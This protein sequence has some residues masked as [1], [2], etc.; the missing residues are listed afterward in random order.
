MLFHAYFRLR[1]VHLFVLA[2]EFHLVY[3]CVKLMRVLARELTHTLTVFTLCIAFLSNDDDVD[4]C[5]AGF[6]MYSSVGPAGA[7]PLCVPFSLPLVGFHCSFN[8]VGMFL[9]VA[10][11]L[12]SV[13]GLRWWVPLVCVSL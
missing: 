13:F 1:A 10:A 3:L 7:I 2:R 6:F 4:L 11:E 9:K 8:A 5:G 12:H